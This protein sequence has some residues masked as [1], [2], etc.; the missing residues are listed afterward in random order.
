MGEHY[1]NSAF[2][3]HINPVDPN[4]KY[5][6][7]DTKDNCLTFLDCAVITGTDCRLEIEIYR[8]QY[9]VMLRY[10]DRNWNWLPRGRNS[11]SR[12][13]GAHDLMAPTGPQEA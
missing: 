13:G 10:R 6:R 1:Q 9:V 11:N 8:N 12:G 5:T 3:D 2:T 7:E 4:I